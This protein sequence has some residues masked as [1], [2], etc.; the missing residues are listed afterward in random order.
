[1]FMKGDLTLNR[2]R[3]EG[4]GALLVIGNGTIDPMSGEP[5]PL[6]RTCGGKVLNVSISPGAT[7]AGAQARNGT[8]E[9]VLFGNAVCSPS[10]MAT[11]SSLVPRSRSVGP[12]AR[13]ESTPAR[14]DR[15]TAHRGAAKRLS[16]S[17][18]SEPTNPRGRGH[19]GAGRIVKGTCSKHQSGFL[20]G[21]GLG[22][23]RGMPIP[24][25]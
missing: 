9:S 25:V 1:M 19:V 12:C 3:H 15:I 11:S 6:N 13:T 23:R 8:F 21:R 4:N 5:R 18:P 14:P 10:P 2:S 17:V 20:L 24:P 22:S 7:A 16:E